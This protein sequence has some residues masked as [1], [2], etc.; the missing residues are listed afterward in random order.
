ML[1]RAFSVILKYNM[2]SYERIMLENVTRQRD[3]L[4]DAIESLPHATKM[5]VW[6]KINSM[7]N[8]LAERQKAA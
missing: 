5:R 2:K 8:V 1:C 4:L 7:D 6:D 3:L